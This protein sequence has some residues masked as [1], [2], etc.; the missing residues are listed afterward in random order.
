LHYSR[1]QLSS[2]IDQSTNNTYIAQCAYQET[3]VSCRSPAFLGNKV[4]FA[5]HEKLTH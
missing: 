4:G 1:A 5:K 3:A 2:E